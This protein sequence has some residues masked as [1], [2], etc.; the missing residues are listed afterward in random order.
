MTIKLLIAF[1]LA[2]LISTAFGKYYVPWLKEKKAEQMV[3]EIGP[4]WHKFKN[5]TPTMGGVMFILAAVLVCLTVGFESMLRGRFV[6]IF[7]LLFATVFGLI[8]F[9]D[10]FEKVRHKQNTGLSARS[11]FLLQLAAALVFVLLMRQIGYLQ[12]NLYVPFSGRIIHIPEWL[13]FAFAAFVIVGTV[14]A[15]NITDGVDGL[16]TGT[17]IPVFLFFVVLCMAWGTEYLELGIF[18]SAMVGGLFGFLVYNYNPA[19]VFMGDTGSLFLGGAISALTFAFDMPLVLITLGIIFIIE[20]LSDIIQVGYFKLS[21][22]KRV[23]RM[24]PLHHHLELGGWTGKKWKEKELFFLF[25]GISLLFAII[26]FIGVY[27]RRL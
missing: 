26:S 16:A 24:A 6:H 21:H 11:K 20:T 7:V 10:D 3:K 2:F 27:Q 15:V 5:G 12:P 17:S 8:G 25:T 4:D 9:L 1:A 19:K 14:N 18:A 22:G 13:Y 23:F